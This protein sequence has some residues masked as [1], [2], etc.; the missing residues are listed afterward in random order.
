MEF[1]IGQIA[2][3]LGGDVI[4][5]NTLKISN[6]GKIES[7]KAGDISFLANP[8]YES[9]VYTTSA[10]AVI[11]SKDFDPKE[12]LSTNLIKVSEPYSAFTTLLEEY[13]RIMSFAKKGVE[14]FTVIKP[15]SV[16][17]KDCY[18]GSFS[19]IGEN[20]K[21]GN[22]VKIYPHVYIGDYCEIGDNTI[23]YPGAK[24]YSQTKVGNNCVFHAGCVV[25][26]D[27]FGFAPQKDGSYKTIPQIGNVIIEDNVSI[28]AN[29]TIDCA[30]MGS[31]I[32][33]K[34]VK[35]D[36][37]VQIAHNVE[38]GENTVMAAQ[39]GIAGSTKIG[40]NNVFGGQVGIGGHIS[41]ADGTQLGA[42]SGVIRTIKEE[43]QAL[44]G[45]PAIPVKEFFK[46]YAI[47]KNL[48]EILKRIAELEEK[49]LNLTSI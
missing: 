14:D 13:D 29:T 46:V 15:S 41:I 35:L 38:I 19:Y 28:G 48:P 42:K 26:S 36:N 34:G 20:C 49:T 23:L 45:A 39:V 33:K 9:Y 6:V 3:I 27:G 25:G 43:G 47:H 37:L 44:L 17:G 11:V 12:K 5:D 22:N 1:T 18:Q 21:I 8:K 10:S 4:G 30:T 31:T 40:K 32:I 16:I 7:A 2:G 24:L